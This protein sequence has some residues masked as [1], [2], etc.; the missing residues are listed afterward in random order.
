[1]K[2]E[3]TNED[4]SKIINELEKIKNIDFILQNKSLQANFDNVLKRLKTNTFKLAVVGEFSSGK[5]TFLNALI[6]KDILKHGAQETTATITEIQNLS[7]GERQETF[8]VYYIDNKVEEDIP[9]DKLIEYTSTVSKIHNV[10]Q[11]IKKVVIKT[12]MFDQNADIC[13]IDTPG[14]NGIADNHREQTIE[15]I[16][17][18]HAC[19]RYVCRRKNE[20]C[21]FEYTFMRENKWKHMR[22]CLKDIKK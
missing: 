12:K 8:D 14:L 16:E 15:L 5:S 6:G 18:S 22:N 10:A 21:R 4:I 9:I 13:L 1:M 7:K 17:N 20:G 11:E 19:D 2:N 3:L